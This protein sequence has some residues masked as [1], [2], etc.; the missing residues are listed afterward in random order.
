MSSLTKGMT[1]HLLKGRGYSHVTHLIFIPLTIFVG[2]A[3]DRDFKFCTLVG[4]VTYISIGMTNFPTSG[5]GYGHVTSLN[6]GK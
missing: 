5:R 2:K 3:K 6:C 4:R 1:Y